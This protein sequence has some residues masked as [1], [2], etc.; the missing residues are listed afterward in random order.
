MGG[1]SLM[2]IIEG[3]EVGGVMGLEDQAV[4]VHRQI[5]GLRGGRLNWRRSCRMRGLRDGRGV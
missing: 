1:H 4:G 5:D 3:L 2:R